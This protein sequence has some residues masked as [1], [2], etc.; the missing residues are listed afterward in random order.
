MMRKCIS[1]VAVDR[2]VEEIRFHIKVLPALPR[3]VENLLEKAKTEPE[4]CLSSVCSGGGIRTH[5]LRIMIPTL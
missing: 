1:R 4:Q 5:D 3:D 2:D